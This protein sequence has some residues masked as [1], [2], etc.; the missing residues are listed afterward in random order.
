[1]AL[2]RY[3]NSTKWWYDFRFCGRRIRESTR[4]SNKTIAREAERTRRKQLEERFNGIRQQKLTMTLASAIHL[5]LDARRGAI[6]E[7]AHKILRQSLILH[8][9]PKIGPRLLTDIDSKTVKDYQQFRI[10]EGAAPATINIEVSTLRSILRRYNLWEGIRQDIRMLPP[11]NEHIGRA[12]ATDELRTLLAASKRSRSKPLY[13]VVVLALC[14]GMRFSEIRFLKWGQ[15]DWE[16][17][18][19][20]VGKSKTHNGQ[21]RE[22]P[23]NPWAFRVV[24]EWA[25]RFPNRL[26]EHFVFPHECYGSFKPGQ[27]GAY[28]LDPTRPTNWNVAWRLAK[29]KYGFK[30]R[31]HDLRHTACTRLLEGGS[32]FPIVAGIMGWGAAMTVRMTLRYGHIGQKARRKAIEAMEFDTLDEEI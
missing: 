25:L 31:F 26:A 18:S 29:R 10:V 22:I 11:N 4:S 24:S 12:L 21:G 23:L 17:R 15:V 27:S 28:D 14:T 16:K 6:T 2:F 30:F 1:M 3:P 20:T 32:Q 19:V 5:F 8:V 9:L 7:N 13:P